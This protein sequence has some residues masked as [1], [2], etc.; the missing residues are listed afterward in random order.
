MTIID[1]A[2]LGALFVVA[3]GMLFLFWTELRCWRLGSLSTQAIYTDTQQ[4]P[5]ELLRA[6][7]LPL[8]GKPDYLIKHSRELMPVEVKT[9]R[10]PKSA[11]PSHIMQLTAYCLLVEE[12]YDSRPSHGVIKY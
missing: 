11:Y 8:V 4:Q 6:T 10:T 7:S 2:L 9:G 1:L 3:A 5:G 12:T